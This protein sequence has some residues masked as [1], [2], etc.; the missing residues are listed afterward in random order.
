MLWTHLGARMNAYRLTRIS[1]TSIII[2][3]MGV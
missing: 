3:V 1:Q 2:K